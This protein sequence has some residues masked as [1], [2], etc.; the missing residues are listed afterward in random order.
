[1]EPSSF[2]V[3]FHPHLSRS[4]WHSFMLAVGTAGATSCWLSSH[5]VELTCIKRS[6]LQHVGY[7]IYRVAEP[8]LGN[9]VGVTGE[10]EAR[11]S[12]YARHA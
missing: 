2:T 6:Q 5:R 8:A 7:I 10:A 4:D 11:G 9:V 1:V 3:E 12:A